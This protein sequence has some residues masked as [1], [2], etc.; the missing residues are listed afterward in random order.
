MCTSS[1]SP[2]APPPEDTDEEKA[3]K[4]A[5]EVAAAKR[6]KELDASNERL[7]VSNEKTRVSNEARAAELD[8][9]TALQ[10]EREQELIKDDKKRRLETKVADTR[11]RRGRRSLISG[12][13]GGRGFI[14]DGAGGNYLASNA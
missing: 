11:S 8:A 14:N 2:A 4:A 5:K 6:Q 7:R 1:P 12:S 10:K 9:Q 3:E 13:K